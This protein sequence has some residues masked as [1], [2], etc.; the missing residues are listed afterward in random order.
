VA[1][2][3]VIGAYSEYICLPESQ[4]TIVPDEND[5]VEAAFDPIGPLVGKISRD[6]LKHL[7]REV[8]W[9]RMDFITPARERAAVF[10][11]ISSAFN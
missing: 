1:D 7:N 9:L 10:C 3:T 6:R 5:G 4:L 2:L 8:S 11:L